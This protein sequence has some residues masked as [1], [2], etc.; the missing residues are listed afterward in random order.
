MSR[1]VNLAFTM[2]S[3]RAPGE[4]RMELS[5]MAELNAKNTNI[6]PL[7]EAIREIR[8]NVAERSD[9]VVELR[10]ASRARIEMLAAELESTIKSVPSDDDQFDFAVSSGQNPRFFIDATAHVHLGRD[11]MTYRFVRDGR[12]GRAIMAESRDLKI[13]AERVTRYVA[14]RIV[15]RQRLLDGTVIDLAKPS[16]HAASS[17]GEPA[18]AN[19]S[20]T[21]PVVQPSGHVSTETGAASDFMLGLIWFLIGSVVGAAVLYGWVTGAFGGAPGA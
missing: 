6:I 2:C 21:E 19:K 15:E 18:T 11:R 10:E 16:L 1:N 20:M 5:C 13:V 9:V 3:A 4:E 7:D 14:E 12:N 17:N 8:L